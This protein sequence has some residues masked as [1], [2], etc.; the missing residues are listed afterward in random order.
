[1]QKKT[2]VSI[3]KRVGQEIF[4]SSLEQDFKVAES[5]FTRTRKLSFFL[6]LVIYDE[7]INQK[8]VYRD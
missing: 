6:Y 1:M 3:L 2:P 8:P 7:V 5:D 4:I